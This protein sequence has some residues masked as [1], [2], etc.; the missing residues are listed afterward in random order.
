MVLIVMMMLDRFILALLVLGAAVRCLHLK[1]SFPT[2]SASRCR[3]TGLM[4]KNKAAA[5]DD[6]SE[7]KNQALNGVLHSIERCYG[8]GSIQKLGETPAMEV[9]DITSFK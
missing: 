8:K 9:D 1:P 2:R 5:N 6:V 7:N 3:S 4:A